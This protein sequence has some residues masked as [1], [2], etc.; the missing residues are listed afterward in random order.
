MSE[1]EPG[2]TDGS[3]F[4][5]GEDRVRLLRDGANAFPAMVA[6]IDAAEREVLLEMYWVGA[7]AVGELFRAALVRAAR[8][9]LVVRVIYDSLGS[10]D[11]TP[12]WWSPLREVGGEVF[13]FHPLSPLRR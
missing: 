3:W 9:G 4:A 11:I 7:D 6:A 13:E 10:L 12:G 8:R 1:A 2:T 5:I